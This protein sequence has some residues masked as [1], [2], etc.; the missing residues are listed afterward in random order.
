MY[1]ILSFNAGVQ[2]EGPSLLPFSFLRSMTKRLPDN[3]FSDVHLFQRDIPPAHCLE[4]LLIFPSYPTGWQSCQRR[5]GRTVCAFLDPPNSAQSS[6]ILSSHL[7]TVNSLCLDLDAH[8]ASNSAHLLATWN[9]ALRESQT[10]RHVWLSSSFIQA[11]WSEDDIPFTTNSN[12]ESLRILLVTDR[13]ALT[14]FL[15][16]VARNDGIKSLYIDCFP[17]DQEN[18]HELSY[19]ICTVLPDHPSLKEVSISLKEFDLVYER[20]LDQFVSCFAEWKMLAKHINLVHFSIVH[21]H[22]R[23]PRHAWFRD[24]WD[25]DMIP[26]WDKSMIPFVVL[27][28]YK[29]EKKQ[30]KSSWRLPQQARP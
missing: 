4:F 13:P 28:W 11:V 21:S 2:H 30:S 23:T 29:N 7:L 5:R 22:A 24:W 8:I 27:N 9:A 20:S 18:Q 12:I 10:L 1:S 26:W 3:Y 17:L 16:G 14:F 6:A 25:K 15:D 19:L